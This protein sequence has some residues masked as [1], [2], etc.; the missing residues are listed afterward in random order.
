MTNRQS[1]TAEYMALFRSLESLRPAD[2]R[3]FADSDAALFLSGARRWL[4][5][6]AKLP[7]GRRM[8][9]G[10][11]DRASPGARAAGIARTKWI[12]DEAE[13]ALGDG[14]QLVLLGAGFDMRG[15]RLASAARVRVSE[16]DHPETSR[17]KRAILKNARRELPGRIRSIET[18]FNRQSIADALANAGYDSS[19]PTCWIWEGVTNYLPAESVDASLRQIAQT[20]AGGS[21][22]IF[23]YIEREVLD[24][25][26]R[27]VGAAKLMERLRSYGEPWTFGL[28]PGEAR[29]YLAA[30]GFV[31]VKD[32][33]VAEVWDHA[34]R[35]SAG[36]RGYEFY[37]LACARVGK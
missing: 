16:L 33:G 3:L 34:G 10:L 27:Y 24:H 2:S 22:L 17:A 15:L 37:R 20:T 35:G 31:L 30:R 1:L 9:E 19:R 26:A 29:S 23:T 28:D 6:A 4:Y 18:D 36:T 14:G 32:V 25:P 7:G 8:V 12:D 21:L 5:R 11:L 13:G